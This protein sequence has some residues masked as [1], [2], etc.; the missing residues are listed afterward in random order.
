MACL[1]KHKNMQRIY[2]PNTNFWENLLINDREL[3]HQITRV[4]RARVWQEYVFFDGVNLQD[5]VYKIVDINKNTCSF[6][7][8][9]II[10]KSS[11]SKCELLLY[12]AFPNKLSK[13]EA[14][15][16]KCS[17]VWY[18]K[19]IF[20]ESERSQKLVLS[21]NKKERL[22]KISIEAIE[23]CGWNIVPSLE[24]V[25][26]LWKIDAKHSIICHTQDD[27]S[28][29][30]CDVTIEDKINVFVGPEGWFFAEELENINAQKVFFWERILRCET[31]G[32]VVWFY[33]S[34]KK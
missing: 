31:V 14:I 32:E 23:Q 12:Q 9:N 10:E 24:Y 25:S 13:F 8:Q 29:T 7:K 4:M 19:I 27:S 28:I 30:L 3:Y 6:E 20:F 22:K 26:E 11:E 18:S 5:H 34:Q 17:E 16:Q 21:D 33:I 2:L 15:V 1:D